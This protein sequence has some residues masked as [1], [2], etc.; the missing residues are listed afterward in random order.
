MF[1]LLALIVVLVIGTLYAWV[2]FFRS[3]VGAYLIAC[4]L[5]P[6]TYVINPVIGTFYLIAFFRRYFVRHS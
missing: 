6:L 5:I 3:P 1:A 4:A 2:K